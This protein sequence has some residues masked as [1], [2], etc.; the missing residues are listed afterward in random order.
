MAGILG[1][2]YGTYWSGLDALWPNARSGA[3][4]QR[5]GVEH[6]FFWDM[7]HSLDPD[8][9]CGALKEAWL[10]AIAERTMGRAA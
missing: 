1:Q 10:Q 7:G 3:A 2:V 6:G 9:E 8:G 5:L 4:Q